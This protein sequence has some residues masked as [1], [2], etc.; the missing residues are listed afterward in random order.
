MLREAP[1]VMQG[2]PHVI[3]V[4]N[5]KGGSGKTTIAMH[6]AVALL[7]DGQRV[8]T[9]D[10]DSNQQSLTR[11]IENRASGRTIVELTLKFLCTATFRAL[12]GS[13]SK[14]TKPR[15]WRRST[16]SLPASTS[17]LISS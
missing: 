5:E 13:S 11:Y 9:I 16:R 12:K 7:K 8:G 1:P 17:P 6:V 2:T 15:S 10:L 14:T 4:G 3:V